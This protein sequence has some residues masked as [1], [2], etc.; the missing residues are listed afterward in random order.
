MLPRRSWRQWEPRFGFPIFKGMRS[1]ISFSIR[2]DFAP[3]EFKKLVQEGTQAVRGGFS[4]TLAFVQKAAPLLIFNRN[5]RI[6]FR[7]I[8][9]TR[10]GKFLAMRRIADSYPP[11]GSID[12]DLTDMLTRLGFQ[13]D[14][15]MAMMVMSKGRHDGVRSSP[16]S[17]SM[18]YR[19]PQSYST[20]RTGGFTRILND[21]RKKNHYG[22]RGINPTVVSDTKRMSSLFLINHS[23]NPSYDESVTPVSLLLRPDGEKREAVFGAIPPFGGVERTMEDLF[24]SD[25][26]DF[27]APYRGRGTTITTC[28]GATL[29]SL[30]LI[31]ARDNMSFSIEHSRP[32]HTYLL[33]GMPGTFYIDITL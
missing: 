16:G 29:A 17:Y 24:G 1:F 19:S 11:G 22:F 26:S 23:S 15:Y 10:D 6:R 28:P 5:A 13:D 33:N 32:A 25:V 8:F 2:P 31:R 30:H 20:Y 21:S 14:D 18:T 3:L 4:S 7:I 9:T 12:V 27:L